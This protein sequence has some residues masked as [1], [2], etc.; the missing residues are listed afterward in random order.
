[1]FLSPKW[2]PHR[3][4]Y[5]AVASH[6][7]HRDGGHARHTA[8]S[9]GTFREV[10]FLTAKSVWV[11]VMLVYLTNTVRSRGFSPSQ[12]FDPTRT[13]WLCFTPHPPIGFGLQSFSR[14]ARIAT[15]RWNLLSCRL[16]NWGDRVNSIASVP[17]SE[18]TVHI[19]HT[20]NM[21]RDGYSCDPER[22]RDISRLELQPKLPLRP[23][24]G[25]NQRTGRQS[26]APKEAVFSSAKD[27]SGGLFLGLGPDF[28]AL[29]RLSVR[30]LETAI[31]GKQ[32]PMLP[33]PFPLRGQSTLSLSES[34]PLIRFYQ[35]STCNVA[36][37][38]NAIIGV[39]GC[40]PTRFGSN[41]EE[42][43]L[44][45]WGL[46]PCPIPT[47]LPQRATSRALRSWSRPR[48][49][50]FDQRPPGITRCENPQTTEVLCLSQIEQPISLSAEP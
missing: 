18:P 1:M 17:V 30:T 12:R 41:S 24:R 50:G 45:P 36:T 42:F 26:R 14:S 32:E 48:K 27:L 43:L 44:P 7:F 40:H 25:L 46:P 28:R 29:L 38:T 20:P 15:S 23:K 3:P 16:S 13:L 5:A 4:I 31:N 35:A 10:R 34:S 47:A 2:G 37:W 9:R 19:S 49:R 8:A 22:D 33:W 21:N 6:G 11:I 39:P